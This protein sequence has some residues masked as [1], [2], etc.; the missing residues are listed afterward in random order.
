M[1]LHAGSPQQTSMSTTLMWVC[2]GRSPGSAADWCTESAEQTAIGFAVKRRSSETQ[3]HGPSPP[4]ALHTVCPVT[5]GINS[6]VMPG[7]WEF[8]IG[9]VGPLEVGDQVHMARYL[10]HRLGEDFDIVVTF[11]P[12]PMKG[13]WN[14][15]PLFCLCLLFCCFC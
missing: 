14:G 2:T 15:E 5:V 4:N 8:Q 1:I 7:Q 6:E 13:D 10:L 12:K 9:P 11:N 3:S